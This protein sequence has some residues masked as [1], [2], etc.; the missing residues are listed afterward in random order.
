M[1]LNEQ[2]AWLRDVFALRANKG[3]DGKNRLLL[4][5]SRL[6]RAALAAGATFELAIQTPEHFGDG[7]SAAIVAQLAGRGVAIHRLAPAA[8]SKLSY[9]A[10]GLI[11]VVRYVAPPLEKVLSAARVMV[12]DA[13]SDPGN[14]GAVVRAAGAWDASVAVIDDGKKLFHP[15]SL[16]AS[17]GAVFSTPACMADRA[18]LIAQLAGKRPILAV[19]PDGEHRV[20]TMPLDGDPIL[21]VGNEK[22][23]VHPRWLEVAT[24][25]I[26]IPMRTSDV[27]LDSLNVATAATVVL[28]EAYRRAHPPA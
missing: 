6:V 7:G 5:G 28:W 20:D 22:R 12:L 26:A 21:V 4:E 15:K 17:L 18:Q 1:D 2:P 3:I 14:I 25:R 10:D 16:R 19:V 23:G 27:A 8:F 11:A 9:K 24:A 13:L